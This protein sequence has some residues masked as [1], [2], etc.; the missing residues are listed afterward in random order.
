MLG[1]Q[2]LQLRLSALATGFPCT[3][4]PED[5]CFPVGRRTTAR[6]RPKSGPR[7]G[8]GCFSAPAERLEI[9]R[10]GHA[11]ATGFRTRGP[12][13]FP[14]VAPGAAR[15]LQLWQTYAIAATLRAV[16]SVRQQRHHL[17]GGAPARVRWSHVQASELP[18]SRHHRACRAVV[19][20]SQ[21]DLQGVLE[22]GLKRSGFDGPTHKQGT[23]LLG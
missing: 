3:G 19:S 10:R 1:N 2:P 12:D 4:V 11:P 22:C 14:H 18:G 16:L 17:G 15:F 23:P 7:A 21:Q 6:P 9:S 20:V 5:G 8:S 13:R